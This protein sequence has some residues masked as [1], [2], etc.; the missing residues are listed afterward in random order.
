MSATVLRKPR[1]L[2]LIR[3]FP[4]RVKAGVAVKGEAAKYALVWE[5]GTV[6]FSQPG[7]KTQWGSNPDDGS[8]RIFTRTAPSGYVRIHKFQFY[9]MVKQAVRSATVSREILDGSFVANLQLNL[10]RAATESAQIMAKDAPIDTGLLR[11]SIVAVNGAELD[12]ILQAAYRP[13]LIGDLT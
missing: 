7:P 11:A 9:A 5:W 6:R 12:A 1:A 13:L 4:D 3:N 2:A 8:R 10:M